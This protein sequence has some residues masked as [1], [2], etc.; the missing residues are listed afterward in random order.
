[1]EALY[2]AGAGSQVQLY[3][4]GN[5]LSWINGL[6]MSST[7]AAGPYTDQVVGANAPYYTVSPTNSAEFYRVLVVNPDGTTAK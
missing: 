2:Q 7:N 1:L 5:T 4:S 6:L 3:T